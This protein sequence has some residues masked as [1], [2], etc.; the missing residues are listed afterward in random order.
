MRLN[1]SCIGARRRESPHRIITGLRDDTIYYV[2][3]A[4][5]NNVGNESAVSGEVSAQPVATW[6]GRITTVAAMPG[7]GQ[8]TVTWDDQINADTYTVYASTHPEGRKEIPFAN[9]VTYYMAVTASNET[10]EGILSQPSEA[11]PSAPVAGW[12]RQTT[13]SNP[14]LGVQDFVADLAINENGRAAV[15]WSTRF[16]GGSTNSVM[17]LN[18]A[19]D[20]VWGEPMTIGSLING[21]SVAITPGNDIHLAYSEDSENMLWRRYRDG[22]GP[23]FFSELWARRFDAVSE[24][25]GDAVMIGD[26]VAS[27]SFPSIEVGASNQAFVAWLQDTV[28][29]DLELEEDQPRRRSLYASRFDG[30]TWH[31]GEIVGRDDLVNW[32]SVN[33]FK[34]DA[35]DL[36]QASIVWAQTFSTD[37]TS[38]SFEIPTLSSTLR[39]RS[40]QPGEF[41]SLTEMKVRHTTTRCSYGATLSCFP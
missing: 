20:G 31:S 6:P 40:E 18:H 1:T 28:E 14:Y 21:A 7:D 33:E 10:G 8:L 32:D 30:T 22:E 24:E 29:V 12:T 9:G 26:S 5:A 36:G 37:R 41:L 35:N 25:W 4:A 2:V 16:E 13:I 3:V 23:V 38:S 19:T 34:L 11:T 39:V 17:S 27:I 15:V